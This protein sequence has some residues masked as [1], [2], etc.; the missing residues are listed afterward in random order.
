MPQKNDSLNSVHEE[1]KTTMKKEVHL[2]REILA[3]MHQEEVALL[4]NDKGSW[5]HVMQ[6]RYYLV[7]RLSD[8]RAARVKATSKLEKIVCQDS[9]LSCPSL[10]QLLP[11]ESEESCEIL[12]LSDQIVALAERMNSQN[13]RNTGLVHQI[14]HQ[15]SIPH[16]TR[17]YPMQHQEELRAKKKVSIATY[18]IKK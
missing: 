2:M 11:S 15:L 16:E 3:N 4:L 7:E 8:F 12:S 13:F 10:E 18:Q 9:H 6:Q 1:L 17:H 14:E 5:N